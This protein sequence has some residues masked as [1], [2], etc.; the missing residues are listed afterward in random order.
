M[1]DMTNQNSR[2]C[3]VD[4]KSVCD[5]DGSV[6]CTQLANGTT[7]AC[8]PQS[9]QCAAGMDA[10]AE[11]VRCKIQSTDLVIKAYGTATLQTKSQTPNSTAGTTTHTPPIKFVAQAWTSPSVATSTQL[12]TVV[13]QTTSSLDEQPVRSNSLT[14]PASSSNVPTAQ[15]RLSVPMI[16]G[17]AAGPA[18]A[19]L[20]IV[21]AVYL[22]HQR[23]K[24]KKLEIKKNFDVRPSSPTYPCKNSTVAEAPPTPVL[25]KYFPTA[26][27]APKSF[28]D[29]C[30]T[31]AELPASERW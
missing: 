20:A 2:F 8:C 16:A 3:Y 9:T 23:S 30:P 1:E 14:P 31:V 18:V 27:T 17:I 10:R 13:T 19:V 12:V 25:P 26:C 4:Q 7:I 22:R 6:A 15:F 24:S 28:D 11:N 21:G 29:K 5:E